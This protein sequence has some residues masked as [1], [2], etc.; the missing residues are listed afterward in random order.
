M[1]IREKEVMTSV[2]NQ[3]FFC[4]WSGG[5]DACLALYRAMRQAGKPRFL[6]TMLAED[7]RRSIAH[8]LPLGLICK[9]ASALGI[10]LVTRVVSSGNYETEFISAISEFRRD[11][12]KSGVF[13]DIDMEVHREWIDRVCSLADIQPYYPL[14]KGR[15]RDLLK[16]L[17]EAGFKAKIVVVKEDLLDGRFLGRI[18]DEAVISDIE[19][20]GLDAS[21]EA[22]EYHTV[23]TDGPIFSLSL[24]LKTRGC[25]S[26]NGR[27]FL[28]VDAI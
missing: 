8:D 19:K 13:G 24:K 3:P 20:K 9:Q 28:N 4:S 18:L 25:V 11:G 7:G 27:C 15:R 6:L 12:V 21:G 1:E 2:G 17:F 10:P 5:K 16:E 26:R 14:W 22:G 23:V